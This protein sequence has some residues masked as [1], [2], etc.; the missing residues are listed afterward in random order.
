MVEELEESRDLRRGCF[1]EE[2]VR[3]G[4]DYGVALDAALNA[5]Q[6][7]IVA[8]ACL[9]I[10]DGVGDHAVEPADAVFSRYT[11]PTR[12]VEG[13]ESRVLQQGRELR[14]GAGCRRGDDFVL[15][16]GRHRSD[17][18]NSRTLDYSGGMRGLCCNE[19]FAGE[20][21]DGCGGLL[22]LL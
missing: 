13:G 9:Q 1:D 4:E 19:G 7:V 5:E 17:T 22:D 16:G 6:E 8:L 3:C 18:K 2:R 20:A 11:D 15:C 12:V 14:G 10:L 21:E